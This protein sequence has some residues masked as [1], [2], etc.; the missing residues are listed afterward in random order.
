MV[1]EADARGAGGVSAPFS[2]SLRSYYIVSVL[3]IVGGWGLCH[4]PGHSAQFVYEQARVA[5]CEVHRAVS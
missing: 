3:A 1:G 5:G 4:C 2:L